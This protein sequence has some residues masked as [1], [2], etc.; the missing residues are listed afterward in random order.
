M[1][2][3]SVRSARRPSATRWS[4]SASGRLTTIAV[5]WLTVSFPIL[6]FPGFAWPWGRWWIAAVAV[7]SLLLAVRLAVGLGRVSYLIAVLALTATVAWLGVADRESALSHFCGLAVGLLSMGVVGLWCRSQTRLVVGCALF[8]TLGSCALGVGLATSEVADESA[9]RG[10]GGRVGPMPRVLPFDLPD[11]LPQVGRLLPG[12]QAGGIVNYN[13]LGVT[14]L[15]VAPVAI[16][17]TLLPRRASWGHASVR[18]L[19]LLTAICATAII[20]LTQSLSVWVAVLVTALVALSSSGRF[21]RWRVQGLGLVLAV[22]LVL[23][24][25]P[26][27]PII[28]RLGGVDR[29]TTIGHR[30]DIWRE[31]LHQLRGSP[32]LGIGLNEFRHT[33]RQQPGEWKDEAHAHNIFLQTALDLGLIGLVSYAS[34]MGYLLLRADQ[35][36]RGP[37]VVARRVAA[38]AALVLTGV[39]VFGVADAVSLG[40]KIGLF[41]WLAGGLI[42]GAWRTQQSVSM[43]ESSQFRDSSEQ[44]TDQGG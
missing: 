36:A 41:Q 24:L 25:L 39:H 23:L 2:K 4:D 22:P 19:G 27:G 12:L 21:R 5:G 29:T 31:G 26:R 1:W 18:V 34:L 33:L 43:G 35:V 14:A 28:E 10:T 40:A 42:L 9:Y 17:V 32:W 20:V 11:R 15:L 6:A 38:G 3:I 44:T 13:A 7:V 16:A 30:L 8:L 37:D